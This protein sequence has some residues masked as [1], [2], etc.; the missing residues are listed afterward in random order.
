LTD[1][2]QAM[3]TTTPVPDPLPLEV[4]RHPPEHGARAAPDVVPAGCCC[5]CCCCCLHTLGGIGGAVLGSTM[6]I[7]TNPLRT[8]DPESP[9]PYRRDV[10]EEDQPLI[11]PTLLY[12]LLVALMVAGTCAVTFLSSGTANPETTLMIGLFIA[13]MILPGLQLG[14]S[15]LA[16][17]VVALFYPERSYSLRRIGK[18][19]LW[20]FAGTAL[21]L[22][23]MGG[24]LGALYLASK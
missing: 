16:V 22:L 13:V 17:I 6:R 7:E 5:C 20:S 4:T 3:N 1:A 14:A 2:S 9:F 12:W 15:L 18:I 10:F 19:T 8:Y 21:G 23:L 24:C 11:A